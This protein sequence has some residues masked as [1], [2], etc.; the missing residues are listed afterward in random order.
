[1]S[2]TQ[3][4]RFVVA[5]TAIMTMVTMIGVAVIVNDTRQLSPA[6]VD[7]IIKDLD[8]DMKAK[9]KKAYDEGHTVGWAHGRCVLYGEFVGTKM[10]RDK[11]WEGWNCSSTHP[12]IELLNSMEKK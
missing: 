7:K 8:K 6:L 5:A 9:V 11:N 10:K 12:V 4:M 2:E 1:M 3:G